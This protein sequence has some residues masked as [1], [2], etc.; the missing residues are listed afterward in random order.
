MKLEKLSN[1][2]LLGCIIVGVICFG[3]FFLVDYNNMEFDGG[4]Y[5]IYPYTAA[6]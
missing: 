6:I 2:A 5:L 1:Y 4:E 3:L